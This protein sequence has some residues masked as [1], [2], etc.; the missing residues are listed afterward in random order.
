MPLEIQ[1]A[2]AADARRAVEVEGNAHGP[3]PFGK[4]L[5]PGPMPASAKNDRAQFFVKSLEDDS[6]RWYK[7]VDS[8]LE[9]EGDKQTVAFAKWHIYTESPILKPREFGEGCNIEACQKLFG[10]LIEQRT[11]LLGD[12][13]YVCKSLASLASW[14]TEVQRCS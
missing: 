11:R 7:V 14:T 10:G 4:V 9:G 8:D 13:P 2:T 5:F 3:S 12:Q 1:P 6:T